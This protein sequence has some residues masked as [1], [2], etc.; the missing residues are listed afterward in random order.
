MINLRWI[1]LSNNNLEDLP[2]DFFLKNV[3]IQKIVLASNA[4]RDLQMDLSSLR[5]LTHFDAS[6]NLLT[7]MSKQTRDEL[8]AI[9]RSRHNGSLSV[10][11]NGNPFVCTC[12]S[13]SF[14]EWAWSKRLRKP[15]TI[16][17]VDL[18]QYSCNWNG[19]NRKWRDANLDDMS[20]ALRV[21]CNLKVIITAACVTVAVIP[22]T[23]LLIVFIRNHKW[24][25]KFWFLNLVMNRKKY[26]LERYS[27]RPVVYDAFVAY[28]ET[29]LPWIRHQLLTNV[30]DDEE[31]E[32]QLQLCLHH[33]DF[34]PGI[35]IEENI[36]QSIKLS[37][38]TILVIS[39]EFMKSS[40]CHFEVQMARAESFD[41]GCDIIIPILLEQESEIMACPE[42]NDTLKNILRKRTY[43]EWSDNEG[44]RRVMWRRLVQAIKQTP[45]EEKLCDCGRAWLREMD[46]QDETSPLLDRA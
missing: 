26:Y 10:N 36:I 17:L 7:Q 40:W 28:H 24:D 6:H 16:V 46:Q 5:N 20:K 27:R 33:R 35:P 43:L 25:I 2:K 3:H 32:N 38:K 1:D 22:L 39:T 45:D 31:G 29:D 14:M 34:M 42:M 9:V 19:E 15:T 44:K 4:L 41:S 30:N 13:L 12:D 8:D 23:I 37:R 11:L 21:K 18:N